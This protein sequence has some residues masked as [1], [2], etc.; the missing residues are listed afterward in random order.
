MIDYRKTFPNLFREYYPPNGLLRMSF[1]LGTEFPSQLIG[2]VKMVAYIGDEYI[3]IRGPDGWWGPGGKIEPGESYLDTI[4]REMLEETGTQ[5]KDFNLFGAFHCYSLLDK[6]PEPG[7][8]WPE[9]YF[10]WGYGEVEWIGDPSPTPKE[11]ILEVA[12]APLGEIRKRLGQ[13]RGAGPLLQE[14]YRLADMLRREKTV[15]Y[16]AA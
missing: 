11:Q 10:L 1:E 15:I 5:V 3:A 12:I 6:A 8:L 9:F 7:L 4:Q 2:L 13:T 14:I 16:D